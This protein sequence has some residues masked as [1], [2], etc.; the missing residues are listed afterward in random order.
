M[1]N[2]ESHRLEILLSGMPFGTKVL[3]DFLPAGFSK[4][5]LRTLKRQFQTKVGCVVP[6]V[7]VSILLHA[8]FG[9]NDHR[10]HAS[11]FTSQ[12]YHLSIL[13]SIFFSLAVGLLPLSLHSLSMSVSSISESSAESLL[14]VKIFSRMFS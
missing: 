1:F 11:H 6:M 10:E 13:N 8:E 7:I 12:T 14:P 5:R 4:L 3:P 9:P 2:T